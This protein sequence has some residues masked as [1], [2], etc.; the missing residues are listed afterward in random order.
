MQGYNAAGAREHSNRQAG[1]LSFP[2]DALEAK[3]QAEAGGDGSPAEV[4][5]TAQAYRDNY[6][7]FESPTSVLDRTS[8][9]ASA[10]STSRVQLVSPTRSPPANPLQFTF[11]RGIHLPTARRPPTVPPNAFRPNGTLTPLQNAP[12]PALTAP[13]SPKDNAKGVLP[14]GDSGVRLHPEPAVELA[15]PKGK[16]GLSS[17]DQLEADNQEEAD[18]DAANNEHVQNTQ[19]HAAQSEIA[20]LH[21][22]L[23]SVSSKRSASDADD[24]KRSS[25]SGRVADGAGAGADFMDVAGPARRDPW[26]DWHDKKTGKK[27]P[28]PGAAGA[29]KGAAAGAGGVAIPIKAQDKK[30]RLKAIEAGE[31]TDAEWEARMVRER[32]RRALCYKFWIFVAIVLALIVGIALCYLW[33]E[34]PNKWARQNDVIG[35]SGALNN[36]RLESGNVTATPLAARSVAGFQV[37]VQTLLDENMAN[38]SIAT[39]ALQ[40]GAVSLNKLD[41]TAVSS[42]IHSITAVQLQAYNQSIEPYTEGSLLLA[43]TDNVTLIT[44]AAGVMNLATGSGGLAINTLRYPGAAGSIAVSTNN[45]GLTTTGDATIAATGSLTCSAADLAFTAADGAHMLL[46]TTSADRNGAS[47]RRLLASTRVTSLYAGLNNDLLLRSAGTGDVRMS[48]SAVVNVTSRGGALELGGATSATLVSGGPLT[49]SAAG[50]WSAAAGSTLAMTSVA[51]T[52]ISATAGAVTA[53][54]STNVVLTAGSASGSSLSLASSGASSL[55]SSAGDLSVTAT[56]GVLSLSGSSSVLINST[57]GDAFLTA[58]HGSVQLSAPEGSVGVA[59]AGAVSVSSAAGNVELTSAAGNVSLSA[60]SDLAFSATT[61]TLGLTA[62]LVKVTGPLQTQMVTI[63]LSNVTSYEID[64]NALS[65]SV[66]E[67]TGSLPSPVTLTVINCDASR[68]GMSVDLLNHLTSESASTPANLLLSQHTCMGFFAASVTVGSTSTIKCLGPA[69]TSATALAL[70]AASNTTLNATSDQVYCVKSSA[71]GTAA[72][73]KSISASGTICS[74]TASLSCTGSVSLNSTA[75]LLTLTN[76]ASLASGFGQPNTI[77]VFWFYNTAL[78]DDHVGVQL[79]VIG[80]QSISS[81]QPAFAVIDQ[82]LV[83]TVGIRISI[84]VVGFKNMEVGDKTSMVFTLI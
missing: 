81:S 69:P 34:N 36:A 62:P 29:P 40:D 70:A 18:E 3:E 78:T 17:R 44:G 53:S 54:A 43:A 67:F 6:N 71:A 19:M 61:G 8:G 66:L 82:V 26:D 57:A 58:A 52:S 9:G 50:A 13:P 25:K 20:R 28:K 48:G 27:K 68:S 1:A 55:S 37:A 5:P 31:E 38:A 76:V 83:P 14:Q 64:F 51:G 24:D 39:R 4:D 7:G 79:T 47:S 59:A 22:M 33:V 84:M 45:F 63:A 80:T 32:D 72:G 42:L 30:A 49:S 21:A 60:A 10:L 73:V 65:A 41:L 2:S 11:Q 46:S 15:A 16:S 75:G 35:I 74:P 56:A 23:A 12:M 77:G